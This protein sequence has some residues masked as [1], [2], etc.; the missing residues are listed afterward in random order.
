MDCYSL[1]VNHSG[2]YNFSDYCIYPVPAGQPLLG[3]I[4]GSQGEKIMNV[5]ILNFFDKYLKGKQNIDLIDQATLFPGI[6]IATNS[7]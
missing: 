5:M 2:H 3:S 1:T 6:E 4:D 7:R